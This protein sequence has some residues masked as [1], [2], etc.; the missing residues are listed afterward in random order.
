MFVYSNERQFGAVARLLHWILAILIL[1]QLFS[2]LFDDF[3]PKQPTIAFHKALGIITLVLALAR[4]A[5][6]A[7]DRVRPGNDDLAPLMKLSATL[8]KVLL[9]LLSVGL[10]LT[11]WLMSSAAAKPI[12]LFGLAIVPPLVGPDKALA[13][14]FKESHE[15][16]GNVL[17]VLVVAHVAAA[18]YHHFVLK[19]SVLRRILPHGCSGCTGTCVSPAD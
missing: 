11:G 7:A 8:V 18:L 15:L 10:P 6:W 4:L 2:G 16:V 19:D 1:A 5:W 12:S 13:H 3:L 17:L 9:A 14:L